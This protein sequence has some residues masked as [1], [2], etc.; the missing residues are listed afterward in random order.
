MTISWTTLFIVLLTAGALITAGLFQQHAKRSWVGAALVIAGCLVAGHL[1]P[2]LVF[3]WPILSAKGGT[4]GWHNILSMRTAVLIDAIQWS[5]VIILFAWLA[6][7]TH[8]M[9]LLPFALA[10]IAAVVV[11]VIVGVRSVGMEFFWELWK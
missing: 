6:R 8:P 3:P 9:L 11:V 5:L 10:T 7:R 1:I 2:F 4:F